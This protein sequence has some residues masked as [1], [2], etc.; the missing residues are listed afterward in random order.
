M[1]AKETTL[2]F[3]FS[4]LSEEKQLIASLLS[5]TFKP[6]VL[7]KNVPHIRGISEPAYTQSTWEKTTTWPR[8]GNFFRRG[9]H[10]DPD[11]F[12]SLSKMT[13]YRGGLGETAFLSWKG[14]G[15]HALEKS[16]TD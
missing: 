5:G 7:K 9:R 6:P 11:F 4:R 16:V 2:E 1:D 12:D 3:L 13:K 15:D 8:A 10:F 14:P